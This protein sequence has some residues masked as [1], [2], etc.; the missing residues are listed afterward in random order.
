MQLSLTKAVEELREGV[1]ATKRAVVER[2]GMRQTDE[3]SRSSLAAL[4]TRLLAPSNKKI[5]EGKEPL[6]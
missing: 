4:P 6:A 2:C 3:V 1:E 5:I